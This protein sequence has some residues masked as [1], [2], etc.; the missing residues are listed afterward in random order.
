MQ[1]GHSLNMI[2]ELPLI[3]ATGEPDIVRIAAL[4]AFYIHARGLIEFFL[5]PTSSSV[6]V[7]VYVGDW[8]LTTKSDERLGVLYGLVNEQTAHLSPDRVIKDRDVVNEAPERLVIHADAI[9]DL[10]EEWSRRIGEDAGE[11]AVEVDGVVSPQRERLANVRA[12][13]SAG[14]VGSS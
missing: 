6:S 13:L 12:A 1:V 3:A 10:A 9:V 8:D 11:H 2:T 14:Q 7:T 4:D 5:C